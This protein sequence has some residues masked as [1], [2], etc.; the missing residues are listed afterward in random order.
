MRATGIIRRVDDLGRV[1]IPKEIRRSLRIKEAEPLEIYTD[2]NCVIFKKY[3]KD[4]NWKKLFDMI[5]ILTSME[6]ALYD[7]NGDLTVRTS[8]A[9]HKELADYTDEA[10]FITC[11]DAWGCDF[12]TVA[13]DPDMPTEVRE[14]IK[15]LIEMLIK[16]D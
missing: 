5:K 10:H 12:C 3:Q 15:R 8:N 7:D 14:Q 9:M 4:F 11:E 16:E 1:V 6:F 2:N 13:I